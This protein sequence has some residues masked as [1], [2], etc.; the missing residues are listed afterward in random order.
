MKKKISRILG[1]GLTVALLVGLIVA[2]V[3]VAAQAPVPTVPNAWVVVPGPLG[4]PTTVIAA[5]CNRIAI[6]NDGTTMYVVDNQP[7][8]EVVWKSING[9]LTWTAVT[10]PV[11][12]GPFLDIAVAPDNPGI[13]AVVDSGTAAGDVY[14]SSNGGATWALMP[15][16]IGVA[17]Y[18][19]GT[20][21]QDLQISMAV[22]WGRE[23]MVC[24]ADLTNVAADGN[25]MI[26][27]SGPSP[28]GWADQG[29]VAEDYTSCMFTPGYSGYAVITAVGTDAVVRPGDVVPNGDTFLHM[30]NTTLPGW[31]A[32]AAQGFTGWPV[33]VEIATQDSPGAATIVGS[34]IAIPTD[35]DPS[36]PTSRRVYV[37]LDGGGATNED[38]Y[39]VDN[40]SVF[41]L[42]ANAG[43]VF[44]VASMGYSGTR[45]TGSLVVGDVATTQVWRSDN[46]MSALPTWIPSTT[47]PSSGLVNPSGATQVV[48]APDFSTSDIIYVGT[49]GTLA[50]D[51]SAFNISRNGGLSF[52]QLSLIDTVI[53]AGMDITPS[54]EGHVLYLAT[55][56]G[57]AA[58]IDSLWKSTSS[59]LGSLWERVN[60][61]LCA[62][63][64]SLIRTDPDYDTTQ[65]LYWA[66]IGGVN[67]IRYSSDGGDT[68]A[69]RFAPAL[70][71]DLVVESESVVYI[72]SGANVFKSPVT[73][74][75][76]TPPVNARVGNINML[77]IAD[78]GDIL[79]GGTGM[80]S[81]STDGATTFGELP[82]PVPGGG[83]IHVVADKD[84]DDNDLIFA[85]SAVAGAGINRWTV[86]T[87][88]AW[89]PIRLGA[90]IGAG[91]G[92]LSG[93]A[94]REDV[95]YG[96][97]ST[98]ALAPSGVERT[99]TPD[100]P[101]SVIALTFRNVLNIG[102]AAARFNLAPQALK[103]SG[104]GSDCTLWTIDTLTGAIQAYNDDMAL[105]TVSPT[106]SA[107]IPWNQIV[108]GNV[109]FT[110]T[111][112]ATSNATEYT[113]QIALDEM[114]AQVVAATV[115]SGPPGTGLGFMPTDPAAP[116]WIVGP[117]VLGGGV[118][119]YMRMMVVQEIPGDGNWSN[120]SA[121]EEFS[122]AAGEIVVTP[123][124]GPQLMAPQPGASGVS[125]N[126][127]FSWARWGNA[128]EYEFILATDS[129]LTNA[130]EG[131]PVSVSRTSWQVPAGTL[132]YSTTYFWGV[133]A[134]AP[135]VSP[136][137]IGSFTTMAEPVEEVPPE[138]I[139]EQ[140]DITVEAPD[141]TVEA[142]PAEPGITPSYLWAIIAIGAVLVIVVIVLIVRTRR[143]V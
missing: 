122:V 99:L 139:V 98:A 142:P 117:G 57:V 101:S 29:A 11:A 76:W 83:A 51:N 68:F 90:A 13:V 133:K 121:P 6:G 36:I 32:A 79:V 59:P 45:A 52:S 17:G 103:V 19:G 81:I 60:T 141:V 84:Y 127:G 35:Y 95:L 53:A 20:V 102:A 62:A 58:E 31:D 143:Q 37:G 140:P 82:V 16:I 96:S 80:V 67:A 49:S 71:A 23:Y 18:M 63:G 40:L 104:T 3:P 44:Q 93:L 14:V 72:G 5:D 48:L 118:D 33:A 130:I 119:Y 134:T 50:N 129:E 105:N 34:S 138:I 86:G 46:P 15:S 91:A 94:M 123:Y 137:N 39:R 12:T 78:N 128:T 87:S 22:P 26:Y 64:T 24:T 25:V 73:G 132:D 106:V 114:F 28:L 9:G 109:P 112:P 65:A 136:Q 41:R 100:A 111:W 47:P 69:N 120:W 125:L 108:G 1:V 38:A 77:N 113:V 110:V 4:I 8:A 107:E 74:W 27:G 126:P 2:A 30:K 55:S 124:V 7:V 85:G 88:N 115:P 116:A 97:W 61:L 89:E 131:T 21:I 92:T 75:S 42:N 10:P 66:E 56:D 135:S 54:P 70:I 43:G